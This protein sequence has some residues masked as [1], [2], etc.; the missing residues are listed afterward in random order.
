VGYIFATSGQFE[1][2]YFW[3]VS[4][5]CLAK[6]GMLCWIFSAAIWFITLAMPLWHHLKIN[7]NSDCPS[8]LFML[9]LIFTVY[10]CGVFFTKQ[11]LYYLL[12][13]VGEMKHFHMNDKLPFSI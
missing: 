5:P 3:P 11:T 4:L 2:I 10:R 1:R 12:I 9:S 7:K 6:E 8:A 13:P